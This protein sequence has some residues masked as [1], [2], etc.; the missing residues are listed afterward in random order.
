MTTKIIQ[1][2]STPELRALLKSHEILHEIL[3][4]IDKICKS[5]LSATEKE[6]AIESLNVKKMSLDCFTASN[7]LQAHIYSLEK[8]VAASVLKING[9]E[10]ERLKKRIKLSEK[11]AD[12]KDEYYPFENGYAAIQYSE[13]VIRVFFPSKPSAEIRE[14]L[15][16]YNFRWFPKES[17]WRRKI[18]DSALRDV[19]EYLPGILGFKMD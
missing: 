6:A 16:T 12:K 13:N 3:Q 10:I 11:Y 5:E 18:T 8:G 4:Q 17:V 9:E 7:L 1:E 2:M 14:A 15:K 19:K